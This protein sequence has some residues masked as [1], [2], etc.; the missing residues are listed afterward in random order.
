MVRADVVQD[1]AAVAPAVFLAGLFAHGCGFALLEFKLV[2]RGELEGKVRDLQVD[3]GC[4][5]RVLWRVNL[6]D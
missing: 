6:R 1:C 4:G 2:G 5:D 3:R